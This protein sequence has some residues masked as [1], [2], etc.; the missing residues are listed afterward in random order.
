MRPREAT[1]GA[2]REPLPPQRHYE[3]P[4]RAIW[5]AATLTNLLFC[6]CK[7]GSIRDSPPAPYE[8][9]AGRPFSVP[10]VAPQYYEKRKFTGMADVSHVEIVTKGKDALRRWREQ[11]PGINLDLGS[12]NLRGQ[13][14]EGCDLSAAI[15]VSADLTGAILAQADLT[16]ANLGNARLDQADLTGA[17][18]EGASFNQVN[19][20]SVTYEKAIF[21]RASFANGALVPLELLRQTDCRGANFG[22]VNFPGA[23][24]S[25]RDLSECNFVSAQFAGARLRR[26]T[27]RAVNFQGCDLQGSDLSG[28]D[29]EVGRFSDAKLMGALLRRASLRNGDF[30]RADFAGAD[31]SRAD[32]HEACL[33]D[34]RMAQI[35]GAP[36]A[37]NLLTTRIDQP[38]QY[39]ESAVRKFGDRWLDWQMIRTVGRLPLFAA[40]YSAL[41]A[42]PLF[43]YAWEIYND[44]VGL[45]RGWAEQARSSTGTMESQMAQMVLHKLHPLAP[46]ALSELLLVSTIFL[47]AGATIYALAC[48]SRVK[49][50]SRDQWAYQL[51]LSVVHYLAAS[52][53]RKLWRLIAVAFYIPGGLGAGYVL[54]SKLSNVMKLLLSNQT[55]PL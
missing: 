31:I 17:K 37:R 52:W 32:F 38:I 35:R 46:P 50:F 11:F 7:P 8:E 25:G 1:A 16:G 30:T 36:T 47:A 19:L 28:A 44:K 24:L 49:E 26:A 40:S 22:A 14:L 10:Y 33:N 48:P 55:W 39:F 9:T 15:L 34:A 29:C 27:L 42:I 20:S 4:S 54:V 23:D 41:I 43:F 21:R 3:P 51:G 53:S 12:A 13:S 5:T 18:C 45:I 2:E 6:A